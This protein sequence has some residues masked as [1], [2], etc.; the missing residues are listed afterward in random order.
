VLFLSFVCPHPR[1]IAPPEDYALYDHEAIPLP[2]QWRREDWPDHPA[3][4]YFRRFFGV[5]VGFPEATIR[6]MNA[7]YY[8]MCTFLD[9][10]FGRVL[11]SLSVNGLNETT[12]IIYTSDHGENLGARGLVGKF[13]MY[14]ESAAIP[15][16]ITGPDVP[17]GKVIDTPISLVDCFPTILET[18]GCELRADDRALPGESLYTI[19]SQPARDRTVF[20][21]YHAV[22]S[23]HAAFMLRDQRYKYIHYVSDKPQLFNLSADPD[24]VNDL[25]HTVV[26]HK[27]VAEYELRLRALLDPEAVDA[28]AKIDQKA[29]VNAFG[30]EVDVRRRGTFANSP[31]PGEDPGFQTYP[32]H[33]Q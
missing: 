6:Q 26:G 24:E 29:R 31:A 18:V 30:G 33:S 22:G 4:D 16:I 14:E 11:D 13:T 32:S 28:Q 23:Q 15:F 7:A 5:D 3:I 12:R 25:A 10:Q 20:S 19:L 1:Y 27:L 8:G 2:P 9:R 21:E 17:A